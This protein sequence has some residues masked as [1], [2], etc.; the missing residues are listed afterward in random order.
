MTKA[1]LWVLVISLLCLIPVVIDSNLY[2]DLLAAT[3][4][5]A[6]LTLCMD[7]IAL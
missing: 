2:T 6:I 5:V 3:G 1:Q 7:L 4:V